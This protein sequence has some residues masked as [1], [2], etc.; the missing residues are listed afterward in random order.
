MPH[1]LSV[2]SW[3]KALHASKCIHCMHDASCT[4]D[5]SRPRRPV[6]SVAHS[7][8]KRSAPEEAVISCV[9]Y[10]CSICTYTKC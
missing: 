5:K 9:H 8:Q 1:A 4:C 3:S 2:K 7:V 10:Q 6:G